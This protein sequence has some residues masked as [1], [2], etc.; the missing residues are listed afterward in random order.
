MLRPRDVDGFVKSTSVLSFGPE[1][2]AKAG[3]AAV[4][5]ALVSPLLVTGVLGAAGLGITIF[6]QT[7]VGYAAQAGAHYAIAHGFDA[8]KMSKD[9]DAQSRRYPRNEEQRQREF[10]C[11]Y[12]GFTLPCANVFLSNSSTSL[13]GLNVCVHQKRLHNFR[14]ARVLGALV[15][16]RRRTRSYR[17]GAASHV[18]CAS[19]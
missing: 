4:E 18:Q 11:H 5:L 8:T 12:A 17:D 3:V 10:N 7:Q 6:R 16:R 14:R 13:S 2:L 9:S 1:H 19:A 15:D